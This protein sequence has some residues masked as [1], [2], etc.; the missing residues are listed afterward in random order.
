MLEA[1]IRR[2]VRGF[3]FTSSDSSLCSGKPGVN[4]SNEAEVLK[5]W[6][7]TQPHS[8]YGSSKKAGA[9][10]T[11]SADRYG[12]LRTMV[13]LPGLILG[14]REPRLL[15]GLN[16]PNFVHLHSP[17]R[18]GSLN[19]VWTRSFARAQLA[20]ATKIVSSDTTKVAGH[21]FMICDVIKNVVDVEIEI[22]KALG[23]P[24]AKSLNSLRHGLYFISYFYNWLTNDTKNSGFLQATYASD[25][26]M[27]VAATFPS[28]QEAQ[29]ALGWKPAPF[30]ELLADIAAAADKKNQ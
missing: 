26:L 21:V 10:L 30:S 14:P 5:L 12:R 25:T 22:R 28:T 18:A 2:G 16:D 6:E 7:E 29:S 13:L 11:L 19:V 17:E 1:S 27:L 15:A 24:N 4:P 8:A 23:L 9:Q 3:V 20:A